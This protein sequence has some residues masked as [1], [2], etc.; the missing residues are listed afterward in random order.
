M[1]AYDLKCR[2]HDHA[3]EG[4]FRSRADYDEQ[5]ASGL[6]A[7]PTCGSCSGM[8]TANSMNCLTE[9]LG[10]SLPGNGSTLATHADRQGLFERAGRLVVALA[11]RYYEEDDASVLPRTIASFEAF[12]NAI[13]T[14]LALGGSTNL[15]LHLLAIAHA[16][17]VPLAL[18]DFQEIGERVPLLADLKPFGKYNMSH[19]IRIGG[20][21]PMM[22][23][24]LTP[25]TCWRLATMTRLTKLVAIR[26]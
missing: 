4:W 15:I 3:F 23:M 20:I 10:L 2:S 19:L 5:V 16:A 12:E 13:V 22:K 8:F 1:I 24:L 14:C 6:L 9:A 11:K 18:E 21:R 26:V 7:C 25:S 17:D